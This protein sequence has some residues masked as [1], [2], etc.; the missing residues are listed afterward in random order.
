MEFRIGDRVRV[1]RALFSTAW[2]SKP[3]IP[4]GTEGVLNGGDEKLSMFVFTTDNGQLAINCGGDHCFERA[5]PTYEQ[6]LL[7]AFGG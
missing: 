6:D 1:T 5:E 2:P 7:K 4:V 3:D